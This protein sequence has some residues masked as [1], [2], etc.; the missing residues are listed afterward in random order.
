MTSRSK[1]V[2]LIC[3]GVLF[4]MTSVVIGIIL[5]IL[6]GIFDSTPSPI[7]SRLPDPASLESAVK[8]LEATINL[9]NKDSAL[10][11]EN[12]GLKNLK[13]EDLDSENLDLAKV[14]QN[15]DLSKAMQV[16]SNPD[17]LTGKITLNGKEI[18][19][20]IDAAFTKEQVSKTDNKNFKN[21]IYDAW[22]KDGRFTVKLTIKSNV[23]TPFGSYYNVE[24]VFI[25]Q[26]LNHHLK[27][28]LCS[29]KIGEYPIPAEKL[30]PFIDQELAQFEQ[31]DNGQQ[32]LDFIKS[33]KID[34]NS[35]ELKYDL[36]NLSGFL[37]DKLPE[38][39]KISNSD[40]K[41]AEIIQLINKQ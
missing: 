11:L 37:L 34:K 35:A 32:L 8:K 24:V 1:K 38:L 5:Y 10:N 9:D 16:L 6:A 26:V 40:N 22:F 7:A 14:M 36:R 30:K 33:L 18:N 12:L 4:L 17:T 28:E 19:A 3:L 21:R 2:L 41:S 39:Q 20:L 23:P 13:P 25:P 31:T 29:A 15:I 27:L